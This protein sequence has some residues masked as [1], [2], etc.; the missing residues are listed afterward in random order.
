MEKIFQYLLYCLP[1]G[2]IALSRMY[3]LKQKRLMGTGKIPEI[4]KA[5]GRKAFFLALSV[6]TALILF[7]I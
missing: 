6:L 1:L 3:M 7:F 5:E 4:L 2:L